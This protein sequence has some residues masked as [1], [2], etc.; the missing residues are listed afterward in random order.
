MS[1][2]IGSYSFD[3]PFTSASSLED[4]SGV[5]TILC[6]KDNGDYILIDVGE[7][8][9]V[10]T[11]VET[12]DRKT[13]WSRN[14]KSSLTVAVLYIPRF[15]QFGRVEIEQRIRAKYNPLCGDR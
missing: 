6:K 3:G 2:P 11:R 15:Q 5:Y 1:I 7:S 13:C 9:T 14:C 12:H 4:R 10:K 8:A